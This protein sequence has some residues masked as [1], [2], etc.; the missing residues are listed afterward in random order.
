MGIHLRKL[1]VAQL[2]VESDCCAYCS[3]TF[4]KRRRPSVSHFVPK[5]LG[6]CGAFSN[7]VLG[8]RACV[9]LKNGDHPHRFYNNLLIVRAALKKAGVVSRRGGMRWEKWKVFQ[10]SGAAFSAS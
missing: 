8:C 6:G 1:A 9:A 10:T 4:G 2:L 7:R 3:L 5:A